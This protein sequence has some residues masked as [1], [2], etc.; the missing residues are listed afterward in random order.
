MRPLLR[1]G[2]HVLTRGDGQV[3]VGLDPREALVLPDTAEVRAALARLD[4][5]ERGSDPAPGTLDLLD[6]LGQLVDERALLPL[7][8]G[9]D[10]PLPRHGA[11]ALSRRSGDT[12]PAVMRA[13][14]AGRVAVAGFGHPVGSTLRTRLADLLTTSGLRLRS[15]SSRARPTTVGALVGVGEPDRELLD[16]WTRTGTPHLVVRMAEGRARVGP[17]VV[18]GRTACLRCVDAHH[19]DADPAWPLLVRQYAAASSRDRADGA[20]EPMDPLLAAL[21][22][23]WA[24]R[25]L[26]T[27]VDGRRPSSWSATLTLDP[28]L[29]ALET[30]TW[31]RHPE[32]GC[33]WT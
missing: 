32:C 7:L 17:F 8:P 13:R 3:Q 5:S 31:H 14:A 19:A 21:A 20:P 25:D 24:A 10:A 4:G 6:D 9:L 30:H 12:L 16:A 2:T 18:P 11:A 33:A 22:V 1:P 15:T 28:D 23:A 26:A 29:A 27:Y